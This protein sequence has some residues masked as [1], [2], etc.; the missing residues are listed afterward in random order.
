[1]NLFYIIK[2]DF[3][4]V[5]IVFSMEILNFFSAKLL[6][7]LFFSFFLCHFGPKVILYR[8]L[9]SKSEK[10]QY[11][12]IYIK[13]SYN[14]DGILYLLYNLLFNLIHNLNTQ[15]ELSYY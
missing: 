3:N 14:K 9:A 6:Y 11:F 7:L 4:L 12:C 1:M 15:F 13:T 8:D 2:V 5:E 10:I